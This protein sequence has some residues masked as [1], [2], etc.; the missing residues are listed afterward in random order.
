VLE[1]SLGSQYIGALHPDT[2]P[3]LTPR[4]DSIAAEGTLLTQA[5]S[6]GNRTIRA[7]E[8]TTSSLPPLPGIS[9]VRRAESVDLF[10]LPTLLR[11]RGYATEF[12]YGGRA[13]FDGMGSYMRNNGMERVIEQQDYPSG[14]F[15][16]AWGVS[17][18]AIFD[19]AMGSGNAYDEQMLACAQDGKSIEDTYWALVVDDIIHAADVLR[20]V[21]D[22]A[23]GGDGLV[24]VEVSPEL[25]HDTEQTCADAVDL[26]TRI[27]RP[28]VMIKIP[29]T[30]EGLPAITRT[31]AA[32]INVNITL[33]FSLDRHNAVID[34]YPNHRIIATFDVAETASGHDR[35]VL[36]DKFGAGQPNLPQNGRA[37]H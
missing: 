6:T 33:I 31:I 17:D 26:H 21:Y 37:K 23:N 11:S 32:G 2:T 3:S 9:V 14:S 5:F 4:F 8:A 30:L 19:K 7:L 34:A 13:V 18:E 15:T 27:G 16:T 36:I 29:A 10:T 25:A 35:A 24:S 28:N 20:P 1:E 22:A 12:I